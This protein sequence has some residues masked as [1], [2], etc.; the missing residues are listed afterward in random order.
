M[1]KRKMEGSL[2]RLVEFCWMF[3]GLK[4]VVESV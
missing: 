1:E 4:S 2:V 3:V